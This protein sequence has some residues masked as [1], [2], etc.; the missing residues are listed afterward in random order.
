MNHDAGSGAAPLSVAQLSI[1]HDDR[2]EPTP[3]SVSFELNAG[4][5][6]LVLGPS[7]SGKSTLALAMNGLIPHAIPAEV[8]GSIRV[9]GTETTKSTVAQLTTRV[10]LVFQDPDAQIVTGTLLDEVC[11][12]PEN[13]LHPV[14]EVLARAERALKAVGLWDR[15]N[16]NPDRLSGGGKQR[17]AIAC[18][19]AL[20]SEILVLDEPTANLDP[21]GIDEV[22]QALR[23]V[24]AAGDRSIVLVEHNLDAAISFVDR[25]IVLDQE[26]RLRFDG[27]AARILREHLDELL[28]LGVW[29][30]VAT[31]A[32][33]KLQRAGVTFS[34]LPL[35]VEELH[36]ELKSRADLPSPRMRATAATADLT[37]PVVSVNSLTVQ[38]GG[39]AVLSNLSFEVRRGEFLSIV[40]TNGV[41]KTTL[42]QNLA[43]VLRPP[44]SAVDVLGLDPATADVRRLSERVGFVFQNPEH[45]FIAGTVFDELAYGLRMRKVPENEVT[46]RVN[47][48]LEKFGLQELPNQHPFLLS[49]G[50]KR[51]LSVGTALITGA[52]ILILD[53]PTFG[54]DRARANEL[55]KLLEELNTSGTTVISVSHDLQLVVDYSDRVMV[56]DEGKIVALDAT[57]VV[58]SDAELLES[59]GLKQPPLGR[60]FA[61]LDHLPEWQSVVR[62][63]QLPQTEGLQHPPQKETG[64]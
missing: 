15:R 33:R 6:T 25:V 21:V 41:G 36:Q 17:L 9:F 2:S 35:T 10:A 56:L 19:L 53:E 46:F 49:G 45:Q 47:E 57:E 52:P 4:E 58:L 55:L 3:N 22:Y 31:L 27:P 11:F 30:P 16:E 48:L 13:L 29:L 14:K 40:G 42:I 61:G 28:E 54:Q 59:A 5:V 20:D 24:A 44:K 12:G 26:G 60:V 38:R 64:V 7:G 8:E 23:E 62:L 63:D 51:R 50:Q 32:A 43:G 39:K 37:E 18:A 34:Q 1:L